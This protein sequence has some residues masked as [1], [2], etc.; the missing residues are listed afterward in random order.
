ME[1]DISDDFDKD[2]AKYFLFI[3][4]SI[5]IT[6]YLRHKFKFIPANSAKATP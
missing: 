5:P 4:S 3:E 2:L 6:D 1:I